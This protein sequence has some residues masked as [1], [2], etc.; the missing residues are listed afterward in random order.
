MAKVDILLVMGQSNA[1]GPDIGEYTYDATKVVGGRPS[2][3]GNTS[4][5]AAYVNALRQAGVDHEIVVSKWAWGATQLAP[6][7]GGHSWDPATGTLYA[8][9]MA[10]HKATVDHY[11]ALGY[12]VNVRMI[13]AQG[14]G[15]ASNFTRANAYE[16]NLT[17]LFAQM[18]DYL[19]L[20]DLRIYAWE[21]NNEYAGY[22]YADIVRAAQE[23]VIT[24]DGNAVLYDPH[25]MELDFNK[26]HGLE[27][28]MF[29][30]G[31][32]MAADRLG[33][34]YVQW[35]N[36]GTSGVDLLI[37]DTDPDFL[38]G[39]E[40]NDTL[41]GRG[42]NDQLFG[43]NGNDELFG[44]DGDDYLNGG[45][46]DNWLVGGAGADTY[47]GLR[48]NDTVKYAGD[49]VSVNLAT[50]AASGGEATGDKLHN[51]ENLNGTVN[52]DT[53]GG[54]NAANVFKGG[55]G[56]DTLIGRGGDD[57]LYGCAGG[58][59]FYAGTGNDTLY[60]GL[61]GADVFIFR[62]IDDIAGELDTVY[63]FG[64]DDVL[65]LQTAAASVVDTVDG[66]L[67]TLANGGQLLF[68]GVTAQFVNDHTFLM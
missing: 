40:G 12:E 33:T 4:F 65:Q 67:V 2:D 9:A 42:G 48:G 17:N 36:Y 27:S 20:P 39:R 60:A 62:N 5:E 24:A 41:T 58:D 14:E 35:G 29:E 54:S 8:D 68:D 26:I 49:A 16:A 45:Y 34:D 56:G 22:P 66:A 47:M 19:D 55:G 57:V 32:R 1:E 3:L 38:F 64:P 43:G 11:K 18:R 6:E 37:G 61:D 15:D 23:A 21:I 10:Q 13:W 59:T 53:F 28:A 25:G 46:G 31:E 7:A 30:L 52:N 51:I 44:G 50:G 63:S